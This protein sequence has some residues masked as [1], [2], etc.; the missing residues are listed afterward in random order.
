MQG[1]EGEEADDLMAALQS[2]LGVDV[3]QIPK[4][5][6]TISYDTPEVLH[7]MQLYVVV[8]IVIVV[9]VC[10]S[11]LLVVV[12]RLVVVILVVALI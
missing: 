7:L 4:E 8:V 2:E 12:A 6:K 1:K 5:K 11:D 9:T 3:E 10:I